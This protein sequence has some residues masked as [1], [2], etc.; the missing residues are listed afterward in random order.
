MRAHER[1]WVWFSYSVIDRFRCRV[2]VMVMF[3]VRVRVRSQEALGTELTTVQLSLRV[4]T[5]SAL[6]RVP[7]RIS[8][9]VPRQT[10]YGSLFR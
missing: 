8:L 6:G 9:W 10:L 3:M 5:S 2:R 7:V 4:A 1:L